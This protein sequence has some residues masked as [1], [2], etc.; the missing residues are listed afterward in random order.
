M[1]YYFIECRHLHKHEPNK[2]RERQVEQKLQ[3]EGLTTFGTPHN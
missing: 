3:Q 2:G 1:Q